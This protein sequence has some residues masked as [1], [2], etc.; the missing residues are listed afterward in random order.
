M[1][2]FAILMGGDVTPTPRLKQQ[3]QSARAIAADGGMAHA[4]LL[5]LAPELWVGDF[6]STSGALAGQWHGVPRQTHPVEKAAS[7]GELAIS[8]ALRRGADAL[9]LVGGLGGQLDHVLAHAGFL[10]ALARRGID[11]FM[12]SGV[13]EAR[14]LVDTVALPS[15]PPGTRLSIM[16]LTD[17]QGLTISGVKWPLAKARVP[18]GTAMTLANIATGPVEIAV[19]G[20]H[21]IVLTYHPVAA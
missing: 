17:L 1:S 15:L 19:D 12:T 4:A 16:P 5:R 18:L 20:G 10:V 21:A 7:D 14:A 3:L 6:D 8:E 9:I 2:K 13:E 11:V